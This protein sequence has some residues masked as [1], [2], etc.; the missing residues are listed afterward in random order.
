M[1]GYLV[2]N[3]SFKF[4]DNTK[5]P[6]IPCYMDKSTTVYPLT[7]NCLLTGPEY[8]LARNQQC[9]FV[10]KSAFF[11]PPTVEEKRVCGVS[12]KVPIQ[13]FYDVIKELQ[14]KRREYSK[15]HMMNSLYKDLANSIY[16]NV[17]RGMSNK[18]SFDTKTGL[19]LRVSGTE[20]SNPIL[21]S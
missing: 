8:L 17:V 9:E 1:K 12:V 7:G 18:K 20:L 15:S 3:G 21:A 13:P 16:G 5:Y 10:F 14:G 19:M 6:S 4:P 2:L 11:V